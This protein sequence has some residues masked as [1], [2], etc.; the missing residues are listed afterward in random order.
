[1][2]KPMLVGVTGSA[3]SG[4]STFG[5]MLE[6]VLSLPIYTPSAGDMHIGYCANTAPPAKPSIDIATYALASPIKSIINSIFNW[7][8]R[9]SEGYLKEVDCTVLN[10][11]ATQIS[12]A[13]GEYLKLNSA[14]HD[15]LVS[16]TLDY[17]SDLE[18]T[19]ESRE[20][21]IVS[22]RDAYQKFGTECGREVHY[23]LWLDQAIAKYNAG[24]SLIITDVRFA[25]EAAFIREH[26]LLVHI[27]RADNA[28][29]ASHASEAGIT[30]KQGDVR[31]TNDGAIEELQ[32]AAVWLADTIAQDI[33]K[34]LETLWA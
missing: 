22:P 19:S 3:R 21:L 29:V 24:Q 7:D 12:A 6:K 10:P 23:T 28:T 33:N 14:Q 32:T 8:E 5:D 1:M 11:C 18:D 16:N 9:H 34:P 4:K 2:T 20:T 30:F 26:G 25:N 13:I 27:E 17:I 15:D 31:V